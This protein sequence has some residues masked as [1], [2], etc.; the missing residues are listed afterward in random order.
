M[1]VTRPHT[2]T[3]APTQAPSQT[4]SQTFADLGLP[5]RRRFEGPEVRCTIALDQSDSYLTAVEERG[6]RADVASL[7]P[8]LRP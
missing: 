5:N 6:R 3:S 7:T 8:L 2:S 1:T 4:P